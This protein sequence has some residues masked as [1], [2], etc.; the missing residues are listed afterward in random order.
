LDDTERLSDLIGAVYDASLDPSRWLGVLEQT[1]AFLNTATAT[2]GSFD[3]ANRKTDLSI[4]W[5]YDPHYLKLLEE[6]YLRINPTI[7]GGALTKAGDVWAIG[8]VVPY[9]QFYASAMYR[10]WGQP[11]GYIDGAQATLENSAT[12]HSFLHAIRHERHGMVDDAMRRRLRLL[13]PHF[14]RAILI[15][16]VIDLHKVEAASIADTLDGLAAGMFLL[17][18]RARIVHANAR[19]RTVV[20]EGAVLRNDG[21]RLTPRDPQAAAALAEIL[22]SAGDGDLALGNRGITIALGGEDDDRMVAHVLPL[23]A[24]RRKQAGVAYAAVAAVFVRKAS[25]ERPSPLEALVAAYRLTPAELRVLLGIVEVGGIPEV[26][27]ILGISE[28]TAKTHLQHVFAKTNTNR[29]ADLVK[30]VAGFINP[31]G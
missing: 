14:R 22:A 26:A 20:S 3:A 8:D 1:A 15:G 29:Q 11:Q 30:V 21:G 9:E 12:A 5:G 27:D 10:E 7:E 28:T 16:K 31:L 4:P 23:T 13:Y 2:L 24:G 18:E 17:D 19:G 25:V 6:R